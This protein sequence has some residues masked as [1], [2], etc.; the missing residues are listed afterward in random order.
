VTA[1]RVPERLDFEAEVGADP[2]E[3][4]EDGSDLFDGDLYVSRELPNHKDGV[5]VLAAW[6]V[7]SSG[8]SGGSFIARSLIRR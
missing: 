6:A 1:N 3:F 8:R 4:F 7:L 5:L 2:F